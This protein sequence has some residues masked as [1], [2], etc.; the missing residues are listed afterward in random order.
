MGWYGTP[1]DEIKH[2]DINRETIKETKARWRNVEA[3]GNTAG[4]SEDRLYKGSHFGTEEGVEPDVGS[5]RGCGGDV[6]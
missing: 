3:E 5:D 6:S 1:D 4:H 2:F